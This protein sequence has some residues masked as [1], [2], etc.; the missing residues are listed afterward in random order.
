M[1]MNVVQNV[2]LLYSKI[3]N[4]KILKLVS[5]KTVVCEQSAYVQLT[6]FLFDDDYVDYVK[7]YESLIDIKRNL[8]LS[9]IEDYT[10]SLLKQLVQMF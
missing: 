1:T 3:P 6:F 2:C 5:E 8:E 7:C 9:L 4:R 10:N